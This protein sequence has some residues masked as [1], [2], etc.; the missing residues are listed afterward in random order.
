MRLDQC[1]APFGVFSNVSRT[2][3]SIFSSPI[4][5]GAPGRGSSASAE[6]PS[7]MKRLRQRPTVNPVVRS[8]AATAALLAPLEHSRMIRRETLP[9][10]CR[11]A[12]RH[13]LQLGLL[14]WA[15]HQLMLLRTSTTRLHDSPRC[16][17]ICKL[18]MTHGT[19]THLINASVESEKRRIG[20]SLESVRRDVHI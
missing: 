13:A 14:P 1:V 6:M 18:F 10:G 12:P 20:A 9:T 11:A 4:S 3:C 16:Q 19:R 8:F 5:R 17:Y 2:T 7:A 15:H